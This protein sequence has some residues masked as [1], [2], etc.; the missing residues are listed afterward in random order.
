MKELN[1][2]DQ[3]SDDTI[4]ILENI[5]ASRNLRRSRKPRRKARQ[6]FSKKSLEEGRANWQQYKENVAK[7]LDDNVPYRYDQEIWL[8][9]LERTDELTIGEY[10][11]I[12]RDWDHT[13]AF[14][15]ILEKSTELNR[16]GLPSLVTVEVVRP[17]G[18]YKLGEVKTMNATNIYDHKAHSSLENFRKKMAGEPYLTP[19]S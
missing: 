10:Y 15:K 9:C 4:E 5:A 1:W 3:S 17:V 7:G 8:E 12:S 2:L 16:V 11:W 19:S 6:L 18:A 14:V 13:G